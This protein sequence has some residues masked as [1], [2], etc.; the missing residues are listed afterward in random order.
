[1]L[2]K[3]IISNNPYACAKY[4]DYI[5]GTVIDHIIGWD[6]K[7]DK[8]KSSPGA[9]GYAKAYFGSTESQ[10]SMNLHCH[11]LIWI[12][13]M[14]PTL[15][16]FKHLC[17]DASSHFKEN[18]FQYVTSRITN[19]L[20]LELSDSCPVCN[21]AILQYQPPLKSAYRRPVDRNTPPICAS[22]PNCKE[23]FSSGQLLRI[24]LTQHVYMNNLSV[25]ITSQELVD[26]LI[27][28]HATLD[29]PISKSADAALKLSI[30]LLEYQEHSWKHVKSCFKVSSRTPDGLTCRFLKPE[31]LSA[32]SSFINQ[33][34]IQLE[35]RLGH[36]YINSFMTLLACLYKCN[37]D[38]KILTGA[39][40]AGNVYYCVKYSTKA[41]EVFE[42]YVLLHLHA[43]NKATRREGH[44]EESNEQSPSMATIGRQR[45]MSMMNSLTSPQEI[46]GPMA[47]LHLLR[48]SPFYWSHT[49]VKLHFSQSLCILLNNDNVPIP[50]LI[51]V[52]ATDSDISDQSLHSNSRFIP[53][54]LD[55]IHRNESLEKLSFYS[56]IRLFR[57]EKSSR[58]LSFKSDH[59]EILTHSLSKRCKSKS[60]PVVDIQ[61]P[62]LPNILDEQL[63]E[64][65][66]TC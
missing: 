19:T 23:T 63:P 12:H 13:G 38:I 10:N 21:A 50:H 8:P 22:C 45:M 56:M 15:S 29:Y 39:Q 7:E 62:R 52:N 46:G 35:R 64:N 49:F 66:K 40:S 47:C 60:L 55:Y 53:Q 3:Q 9:F 17:D 6:R 26:W 59:P 61:G 30:T 43:F 57:K 44:T 2:R 11:M 24:Y 54:F 41:Q 16:H 14:P 42:N 36:D 51:V 5:I 28:S 48:K 34:Q 27:C 18:F 4:Y 58:G 31:A 1:M 33:Y 32:S 65:K 20:P 25:D 37:H